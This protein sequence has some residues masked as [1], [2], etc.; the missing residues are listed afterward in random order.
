VLPKTRE[1]LLVF[2]LDDLDAKLKMM[3]QHLAGDTSDSDFTSFHRTLGRG[4]F[5][6]GSREE[7]PTEPS[8][9]AEN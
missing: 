8:P 2:Y 9:E 3:E 7:S 5:K 1:A 4:L 6:G